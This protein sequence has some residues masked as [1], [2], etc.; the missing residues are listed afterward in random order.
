LLGQPFLYSCAKNRARKRQLA[1]LKVLFFGWGIAII[2]A[3]NPLHQK[4]FLKNFF[5]FFKK[6]LYNKKISI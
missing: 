6:N 2:Q 4:Q 3:K 5:P 1:N